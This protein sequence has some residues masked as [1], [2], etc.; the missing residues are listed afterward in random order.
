MLE[1][2]EPGILPA[3]QPNLLKTRGAVWGRIATLRAAGL[4]AP[5]LRRLPTAAIWWRRLSLREKARSTA[6]TLRR[7]R[8]RGLRRPVL[9]PVAPPQQRAAEPVAE[10]DR[11]PTG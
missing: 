5:R 7:V 4:M 2:V 6:G 10:P 11:R 3:S 8:Q 9:L 1:R